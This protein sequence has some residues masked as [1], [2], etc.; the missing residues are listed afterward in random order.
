[1]P[2][3]V[4]ID[5]PAA[6]GK[7]TIARKLSEVLDFVYINSGNY[8]RA[9]TYSLVK[10]NINLDDTDL[11]SRHL[12]T[13]TIEQKDDLLFLDGKDISETIRN[14]E[15]TSM[16]SPVAKIAA[17]RE[18]VN[19]KLRRVACRQNSIVEGR[20]IGTVVFPDAFLKIFLEA[21]I[22]ER[23]R[24]RQRDFANQNVDIKLEVLIEEISKRDNID[25]T[26]K[27]APLKCAVDALV[28]DSTAMSI[29]EV[30]ECVQKNIRQRC[31]NKQS[32]DIS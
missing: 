8:Y 21:S 17:V 12:N 28:L 29:D 7:S 16:V 2:D 24:R 9:I 10:N 27:N 18:C 11:I 19:S 22:E 3:V 32:A 25:S 4:T 5:G 31:T 6:S 1:M 15:V 13:L 26:R 20:D 30:V 23:A 14:S